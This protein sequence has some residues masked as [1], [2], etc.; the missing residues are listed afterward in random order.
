MKEVER[1]PIYKWEYAEPGK[2]DLWK[3]DYPR[4][5]R[6]IFQ[7]LRAT[8]GDFAGFLM[9]IR[10]VKDEPQTWQ[11]PTMLEVALR[12]VEPGTPILVCYYGKIPNRKSQATH[13]F[14]VFHLDNLGEKVAAKAIA[15]PPEL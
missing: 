2:D 9:E 8:S 13:G 12:A 11:C 15:A 7:N 5:L 1:G 3:G 10:S 14:R 4:E 6:G